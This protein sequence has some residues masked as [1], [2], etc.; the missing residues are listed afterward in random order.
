MKIIAALITCHN[1]KAKT[2]ACLSSLYNCTM[3]ENYAFDVFLV[4]DGCTD[5]T[6][7]IIREKFPQINII[8]GN[9]IGRAHV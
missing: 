3:P 5:G 8:Q 1:R 6:A 4:D 7:D 2:L 9:E